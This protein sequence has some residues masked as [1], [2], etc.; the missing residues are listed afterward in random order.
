M[1]IYCIT[2]E[3]FLDTIQGLVVRGL[4]FQANTGNFLIELEGGY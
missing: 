2:M 1:R 3:E 4:T